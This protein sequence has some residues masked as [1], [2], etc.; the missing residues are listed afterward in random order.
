M[1]VQHVCKVGFSGGGGG[2]D[3]ENE[4]LLASNRNSKQALVECTLK[5]KLSNS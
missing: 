2:D 1:L 4:R 5:D 3:D